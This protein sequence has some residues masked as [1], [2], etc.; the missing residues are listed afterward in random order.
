MADRIMVLRHGTPGRGSAAP[1][2]CC[3]TPQEDYTR[4]LWAV[5]KLARPDRPSNE[6]VLAVDDVT[7]TYG[8]SV[9]VLENVTVRVP[10]GRTVAVVGE[11]GSGKSTLARVI[12]GLLPPI[13][14]R[15]QFDG[16]PSCRRR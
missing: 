4:S 7:A 14:G 6:P 5:R 10:R 9:K 16:K 8:G 11:S 3:K 13:S 1:A 15:I 12:T 2:S